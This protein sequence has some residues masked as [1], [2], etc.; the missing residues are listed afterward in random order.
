MDSLSMTE[1]MGKQNI[2]EQDII[3]YIILCINGKELGANMNL[4]VKIDYGELQSFAGMVADDRGFNYSKQLERLHLIMGHRA[5][6]A[7]KDMVRRN[8]IDG[9]N[10]SYDD[11]KDKEIHTCRGCNLGGMKSKIVKGD[12]EPGNYKPFGSNLNG[13]RWKDIS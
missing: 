5:P 13:S 2:S 12:D 8:L 1:T 6:S 3:I 4:N 7:I 9:L 10:V 11:I